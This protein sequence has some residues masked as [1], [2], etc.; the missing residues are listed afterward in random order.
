[1]QQLHELKK[2]LEEDRPALWSDLPDLAL[3]MDQIIAYMPKQ[4]IQFDGTSGL[5]SAM[6]NNYIKEGL[7]PRAEG[8]R[9]GPE[10]IS[11]L[12]AVCVMKHVLSVKEMSAL[13]SAGTASDKTTDE[14]YAYFCRALDDAL[15]DTATHINPDDEIAD[16][17]RLGLMLALRSYSYQL[18]CNRVLAIL[19]PNEEGEKKKK[20]KEKQKP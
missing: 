11:F 19:A 16:L 14:L 9:Y 8:K 10:H 6:V 3:Y 20:E 17:P 12:T 1:M 2:R 5:T 15:K 7:V 18:A 4:L 13:I